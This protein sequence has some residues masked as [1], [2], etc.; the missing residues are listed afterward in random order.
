MQLLTLLLELHTNNTFLYS[1]GEQSEVLPTIPY[2][3][4]TKYNHFHIHLHTA[5]KWFRSLKTIPSV[6]II[7]V[8]THGS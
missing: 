2:R 1:N 7:S 8:F 6:F 5:D 3:L 4:I